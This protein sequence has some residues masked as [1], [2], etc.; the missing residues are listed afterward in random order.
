MR[1]GQLSQITLSTLGRL[2][3]VE[4]FENIVVRADPDAGYVRLRDIARQT[5]LKKI[6][7]GFQLSGL[8][9]EPRRHRV[10]AKFLEHPGLA[11]RD[12]LEHVADV[13][14]GYGAGRAA[15]KDLLLDA[16]E[17]G[18]HVLDDGEVAVHYRIHQGVEN[19]AGAVLE[20]MGFTLG[21][22]AHTQQAV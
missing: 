21:P 4:Q 14:A 3:T 15:H 7:K 5:F 19:K 12:R 9:R 17:F 16:F 6:S 1:N 18:F 11:G 22:L 10:S 8:N 20:Q 13:H 2:N